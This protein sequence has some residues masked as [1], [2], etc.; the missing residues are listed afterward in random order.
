MSFRIITKIFIII[1]KNFNHRPKLRNLVYNCFDR[2]NL[3]Q[4]K[5][6][7]LIYKKKYFFNNI[8]CVNPKKII[9]QNN[10]KNNNWRFLY[11]FVK[12]LMIPNFSQ[13]FHIY[14]GDWDLK[15][16][17]QKFNDDFK[18]QSFYQHFIDGLNWE[19]TIYYKLEAE[20]YFRGRLR[21][22]YYSNEQLNTRFNYLDILYK[23][24][25][26]EGLKTQYELIISEG[27][28][29]KHGRGSDLRR[30]IDDVSVAI[31]RNGEIVFLDGRHRLIIAKILNLKRIPVRILFIHPELILKIKSKIKAR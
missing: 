16:N 26:S 29:T 30:I 23:K 1:S 19:D 14:E 4:I 7:L 22:I 3:V 27:I 11:K 5:F 21:K 10:L 17:M 24:I 9:F 13:N 25:M 31:S 6:K 2:L 28:Y 18:Y 12:P 15:E 20:K 8:I